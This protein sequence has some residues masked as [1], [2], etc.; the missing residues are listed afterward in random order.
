[1]TELEHI[2]HLIATIVDASD[3]VLGFVREDQEPCWT[4]LF[5]DELWVEVE[6]R[7]DGLVSV[8]A[9]IGEA[10]QG[11]ASQKMNELLLQ[12]TGLSADTAASLT[13]D[14]VLR[15]RQLLAPASLDAEPLRTR[16]EGFA[17]KAQVWRELLRTPPQAPPD[18]ATGRPT[19]YL[20]GMR[21]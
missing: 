3:H 19:A 13:P 6:V 5:A 1:M 9:S 17:A 4:L 14:G 7:D 15:L 21:G 18:T 11:L 16:L 12:Y 8:G 2:D 10:P 20:L